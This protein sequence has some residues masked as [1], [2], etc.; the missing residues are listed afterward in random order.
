MLNRDTELKECFI[1]CILEGLTESSKESLIRKRLSNIYRKMKQRCYTKTNKDY[2]KYGG[3]GIT[4]CKEWLNDFDSFVDWA[5]QNNYS[6]NLTLDRINV[7]KGYTPKNCRWADKHI[8]AIN[9]RKQSNNTS[10]YIGVKLHNGK[11]ISEITINKKKIHIGS[12]D[13]PKSAMKARN[14]YIKDNNLTKEYP[15]QK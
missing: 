15:L 11:W 5:L 14:K 13:D 12:F 10:G 2:Y 8:Q 1:N 6:D 3:R 7:N 4:I 9:R